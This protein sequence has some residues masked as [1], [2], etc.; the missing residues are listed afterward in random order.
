MTS[1]QKSL[2][3]SDLC[4]VLEMT[5]NLFSAAKKD[6]ELRYRIGPGVFDLH[7]AAYALAKAVLNDNSVY[8]LPHVAGGVSPLIGSALLTDADIMRE[9]DSIM[10]RAKV[11]AA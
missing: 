2:V 3:I 10:S 9:H 7:N 1:N 4:D 8:C 6:K 11:I 5:E